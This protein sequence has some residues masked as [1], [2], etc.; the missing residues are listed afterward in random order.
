MPRAIDYL[1]LDSS[2]SVMRFSGISLQECIPPESRLTVRRKALDRGSAKTIC[3]QISNSFP[4]ANRFAAVFF[5]GFMQITPES[6]TKENEWF[7]F[8]QSGR[9]AHRVVT[10]PSISSTPEETIWTIIAPNP[11]MI[12]ES[13]TRAGILGPMIVIFSNM[14]DFNT[15]EK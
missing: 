1:P 7:F 15:E 8:L 12:P 5:K 9:T 4:D 6:N 13:P 2:P 11:Y 14:I 3:E 10:F